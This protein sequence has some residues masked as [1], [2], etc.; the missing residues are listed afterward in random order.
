MTKFSELLELSETDPAGYRAEVERLRQEDPSSYGELIEHVRLEILA[1]KF[2][3]ERRTSS[4]GALL[5]GDIDA[6][7]L[8]HRA[9]GRK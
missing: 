5:R 3:R 4:I 1:A 6:L 8:K 9:R 2:G 7:V